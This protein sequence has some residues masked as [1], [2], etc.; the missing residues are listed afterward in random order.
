MTEHWR[1]V[2]NW[3]RWVTVLGASVAAVL[4]AHALETISGQVTVIEA[5]Y[6]PTKITFQMSMGNTSCPAGT[7]LTWQNA[8]TSNNRAVLATLLT[9]A[10][11]GRNI[12]FVINNGDTTCKGLFLHLLSG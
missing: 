6:M 2:G 7:W 9:A 3:A 11:S 1:R 12:N 4:P 5:T 8:D 10:T